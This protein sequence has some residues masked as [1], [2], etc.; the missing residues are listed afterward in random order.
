MQLTLFKTK[1]TPSPRRAAVAPLPGVMDSNGYMVPQTALGRTI[2][3]HE[4]WAVFRSQVL[5]AHSEKTSEWHLKP[6]E[7]G[8]WE[9]MMECGRSYMVG[10]GTP[11][12]EYLRSHSSP[13]SKWQKLAYDWALQNPN[14]ILEVETKTHDWQVYLRGEYVEFALPHQER[15]GEKHYVTRDGK[16]NVLV[17]VD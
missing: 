6:G 15:G 16:T 13:L 9:K 14:S 1:N 4:I 11:M 17:N 3:T 8:F 12:K 5:I 2:T 7:Y 10:T